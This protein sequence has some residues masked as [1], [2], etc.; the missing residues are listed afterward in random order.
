MDH[1]CL[2]AFPGMLI[3]FMVDFIL[4]VVEQVNIEE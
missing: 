4:R 3:P 2:P 1:Y